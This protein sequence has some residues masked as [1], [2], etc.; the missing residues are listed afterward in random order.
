MQRPFYPEGR[1]LSHVYVLHPPGGIVAGD[2][3]RINIAVAQDAHALLT[4]PGAGKLYRSAA[5]VALVRQ[6][7]SVARGAS[8]EWFPQ[9]TIA[10]NGA[11]AD[12]ATRIALQ[13]GATFIGWDLI[14]LGRPRAGEIFSSGALRTAVELWRDD[15]PLW[16]DRGLLAPHADSARDIL[17]QPWGLHDSPVLGTFFAVPASANDGAHESGQQLLT[18]VREQWSEVLAA[19][20]EHSTTRRCSVTLVDGVLV[21][22]YLGHSTEEVRALFMKLWALLRPLLIGRAICPPRVWNT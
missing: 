7:L 21:C 20:V 18:L 3:L 2:E 8:L 14:C 10:F 5:G 19:A 6:S 4:T 17:R 9:E 13:S 12:M 16:I 15:L 1:E 11:R 22:R